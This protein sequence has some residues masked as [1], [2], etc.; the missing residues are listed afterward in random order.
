M[1]IGLAGAGILT[2]IFVFIARY[3]VM[4]VDEDHRPLQQGDVV[5][6][7]SPISDRGNPFRHGCDD[8]L[9]E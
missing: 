8:T 5:L 1:W 3:S 9:Y 6:P 2:L 4:R 7:P